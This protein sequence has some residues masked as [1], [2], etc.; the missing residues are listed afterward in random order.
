[1]NIIKDQTENKLK[2]IKTVN[3]IGSD[4]REEP[5]KKFNLDFK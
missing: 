1:L 5:L 4:K 3:S 2:K